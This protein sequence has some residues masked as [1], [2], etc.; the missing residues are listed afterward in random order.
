MLDKLHE[1]GTRIMQLRRKLR[2]RTDP[3]GKP[4]PGYEKNCEAI[5]AEIKRLENASLTTIADVSA[6]A[7]TSPSDAAGL[8]AEP[9]L[10]GSE[11]EIEQ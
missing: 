4:T 10:S 8:E 6:S 11:C 7:G 2:A 5:R 1:K 9:V 3:D